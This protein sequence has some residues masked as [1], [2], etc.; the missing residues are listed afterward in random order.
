MKNDSGEFEL[1]VLAV[2]D[3]RGPA[4]AARQ[5]YRESEAS[6]VAREKA[7][8]ERRAMPRYDTGPPTK[9]SKRDRRQ[10]ERIRRFS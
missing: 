5:L 7:A 2:S 9:P 10:I 3:T 6:R 1:E 4:P 8:E